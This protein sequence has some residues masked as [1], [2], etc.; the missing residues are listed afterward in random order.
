VQTVPRMQR[1]L[2]RPSEEEPKRRTRAQDV[3]SLEG[4]FPVAVSFVQNDWTRSKSYLT[5]RCVARLVPF[6]L[7]LGG[8][9]DCKHLSCR[10][11]CEMNDFVCAYCL[12]IP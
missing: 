2:V 8:I 1:V 11:V 10:V 12:A 6:A 7:M 9:N 4:W 5:W 3:V